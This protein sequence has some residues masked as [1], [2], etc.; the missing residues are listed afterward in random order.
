[1]E[2]PD[3]NDAVDS[4]PAEKSLWERFLADPEIGEAERSEIHARL[5]T[6]LAASATDGMGL[7]DDAFLAS[8]G[9][10]PLQVQPGWAF[11][12]SVPA[13]AKPS[14]A[15]VFFTVAAVL[16]ALRLRMNDE[17]ALMQFEHSR[18]LIS[19]ENFARFND[20]AVQA[21]LLRA[22]RRRELNYGTTRG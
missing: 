10:E 8:P 2:L 18:R 4:W 3:E 16:H 14:Q 1:M 9:G 7:G 22:A 20:P 19:P 5:A 6:I 11:F 21:A 12:R 15:D 13:D 17:D